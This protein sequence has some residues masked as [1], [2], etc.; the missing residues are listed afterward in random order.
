M[1]FPLVG[2]D[3]FEGEI[4]FVLF[5]IVYDPMATMSKNFLLRRQ[6]LLL[7][8]GEMIV[9]C[10]E[11][12]SYFFMIDRLTHARRRIHLKLNI[13]RKQKLLSSELQENITCTLKTH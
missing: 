7:W 6:P 3:L 10:N 5:T 8:M 2:R 1:P 9:E 13:S 4:S 11:P 12:D